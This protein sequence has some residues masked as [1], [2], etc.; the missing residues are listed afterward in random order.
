[1][2]PGNKEKKNSLT[3]KV[4]TISEWYAFVFSSIWKL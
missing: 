4:R 2:K 3:Q 1:M